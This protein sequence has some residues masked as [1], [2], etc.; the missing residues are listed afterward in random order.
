[1]I[2]LTACVASRP[3]GRAGR[4][5]AVGGV[6]V[7]DRH[8][9]GRR[10]AVTSRIG[11]TRDVR[12]QQCRHVFGRGLP[13][14]HSNG[15][16]VEHERVRCVR[17]GDGCDQCRNRAARRRT[18]SQRHD[19]RAERR[20]RRR[21][22]EGRS[23]LQPLLES[24]L[25]PA[26]AGGTAAL[27]LTVQRWRQR[28]DH[29]ALVRLLSPHDTTGDRDAHRRK[30]GDRARRDPGVTPSDVVHCS[31]ELRRRDP[32]ARERH[33][34]VQPRRRPRRDVATTHRPGRRDDLH[35]GRAE[36]WLVPG[37]RNRDVRAGRC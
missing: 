28:P 9:R 13:V 10:A 27:H 11:P 33:R 18:R 20:H 19:H 36:Q 12:Q 8:G 32:R 17:V 15:F 6:V 14:D 2:R 4:P 26:D 37:R 35:R 22:R 1:M 5:D 24:G 25:P 34:H 3:R 29:F 30:G 16:A 31:R 7:G 21:H 23:G